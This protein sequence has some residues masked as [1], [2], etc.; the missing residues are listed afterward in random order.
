MDNFEVCQLQTGSNL[1]D[2][3]CLL[4]NRIDTSDTNFRATNGNDYAGQAPART[5]I[6]QSATITTNGR[7]ILKVM[8]QRAYGRQA[9]Q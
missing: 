2:K 7:V 9:V 6:E 5:D 3:C 8:T 4:G 1:L